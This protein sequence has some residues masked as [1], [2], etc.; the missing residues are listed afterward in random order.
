MQKLHL[1]LIV[2]PALILF[3]SCSRKNI[4]AVSA[5][6]TIKVMTYNVHHCNP[7]VK[8][9][10]IDIDAIAAV[11]KKEKPDVIALQ[12]IDVNT[13]RSGHINEAEQL[14]LKAGYKSFFFAK[15]IDFDGGQYGVAILSKYPLSGMKVHALPTDETA[16]GEH[17]VLAIG[18]VT[19]PGGKTFHFACTHLDAER[20]DASR[21]LQIKEIKRLT[22]ES[23]YP[24]IIAGDFNAVAGSSVINILD[25]NFT[26][27]C[28]NCKSTLLEDG[29]T[30]AIDF[31]A[32]R[33]KTEFEVISHNVVNE[34]QASDH[35]PVI[36][37]IQLKF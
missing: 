8:P 35:M 11:I 6:N 5:N 10:V 22:E 28:S 20:N 3:I 27:T 1:R 31:I 19:L 9:G 32:F 37:V 16:G 14:A 36:A 2:I 34:R 30:D 24:L 17:R 13:G 33:S 15:A 7:P 12:E 18:T 25:E 26:R 21:L 23:S 29:N 4:P